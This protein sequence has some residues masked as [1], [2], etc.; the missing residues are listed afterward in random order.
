MT[1]TPHSQ[2]SD[3]NTRLTIQ[4]LQ[5]TPVEPSFGS[6]CALKYDAS[7]TSSGLLAGIRAAEGQGGHRSESI[8][9]HVASSLGDCCEVGDSVHIQPPGH[10][11]LFQTAR[12]RVLRPAIGFGSQEGAGMADI[13]IPSEDDIDFSMKDFESLSMETYVCPETKKHYGYVRIEK[14]TIESP[15]EVSEWTTDLILKIIS[16]FEHN[17]HTLRLRCR[18]K[19]SNTVLQLWV[20]LQGGGA[21]AT[22]TEARRPLSVR[23]PKDVTEPIIVTFWDFPL[24]G[25]GCLL[26]WARPPKPATVAVAVFNYVNCPWAIS[27][28]EWAEA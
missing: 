20:D 22:M 6:V 8:R 10:T 18:P 9:V 21:V 25:Q 13:S 7:E 2:A 3:A 14:L 5:T 23:L 24:E 17:G 4:V 19:K 12:G 1:F 15:E 27:N 26:G 11:D 16:I 28:P